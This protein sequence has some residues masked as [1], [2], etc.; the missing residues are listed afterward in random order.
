M[1]AAGGCTAQTATTSVTVNPIQTA[2]VNVGA[3]ATTICL[4]T[5]VTFTATPTNG[6]TTPSY[7]WKLNGSNVGTDSATYT[8]TTLA[9]G[10]T[11]SVVM[12]S[13]ASPCLTGSPAT[14]NSISMI[15]DPIT[16]G[17]TITGGGVGVCQGATPSDLTLT[18]QTGS[19]LRWEKSTDISFSSPITIVNSATVLS[20]STIGGLEAT[21]YFR[22]VV[23]SGICAVAYSDVTAL[24]ITSTTWN[25][26]QWSDGAPDAST[27]VLITG[28]FTAT[29]DLYACNLTVSNNA[30]VMI[31]QGYDVILSGAL[32]VGTGSTFTLEH[33]SNLTQTASAS[34]AVNTGKIIVKEVTPTLQRQDYAMFSS[35]VIGQK[36]QAFSPNTLATRFYTY[37]PSSNVYSLVASPSATDFATGKGYLIRTPNNHPATPTVWTANY[38]GTPFNGNLTIPV[39][40][41]TYNAIGNPYPSAID[42][43]MFFDANGLTEA[44]YFYRKTNGTN[45]TAYATYTKTGGVSSSVR[46][47]GNSNG[48]SSNSLAPNGIIPVGQGFIV[49]AASSSISFTNAMRMNS[50]AGVQLRS[51]VERHRVWLSMTNTTGFFSQTL[52]AYMTGATNGIDA[53][54]DGRFF[55]DSQTAFTSM[56][57]G[58]EYAI[59]GRQLPFVSS[60]VVAMGFKTELA[61]TYSINLDAVDGIFLSSEVIYL[62]DKLTNTYTNMRNG[63]Y[64]F[65]SLPGVFNDRFELRFAVPPTFYQDADGDGYG[66][67]FSTIEADT[68]PVGYVANSSDCDDAL[69]TVN[70]NATEILGNGIDD[71][72]D[73][74]VDESSYPT[75]VLIATSCGSTLTNLSNTLFANNLVTYTAQYGA[76]Q[77]YR[78]EVSDGQTVRVYNAIANSFNLL[79]LPGGAT[80]G[81]TY[82]VRV[83]VKLGGFWRPYGTT[84][85][86][87]TPAVPNSTSI[88][89]PSC[90]SVMADL[91]SSVFCNPVAGASGYRFRV[92]NGDTIVGSY[93]STI[94][95]FSFMN[96]GISNFAFGVTYSIDV[97]LKF[98]NTWRPD[99]EYGSVCTITSPAAPASSRIVSPLCGSTIASYWTSIFA[100]QI[101]GAEGY[102]FEVSTGDQFY[103]YDSAVSRFN[104]RNV[105]GLPLTANTTYSIRVSVLYNAVYYDYGSEC[106]VTTAAVVSRIADTTSAENA[107][108]SSER[109]LGSDPIFVPIPYPNPFVETFRIA[110]P[111]ERG[112]IIHL[113]IYDLGGKLIAKE[114]VFAADMESSQFG[115]RLQSGDYLLVISQGASIKSMHI[116]KR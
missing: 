93:D 17:G 44:L 99:T 115:S 81:T 14:S 102:R 27:S 6:G 65:S 49:K 113:L 45:S 42:A 53:A 8:S 109:Q 112:D 74:T 87:T 18:G 59:Q 4:G 60:D 15:V 41:G 70:V 56:I 116:N 72:C 111:E 9:N 105:V 51:N 46:N 30:S 1:A 85:S 58:Q 62:K 38:E 52:V 94:N 20:G 68:A 11:V 36:L 37:N 31:P 24:T 19:V 54:I 110:M 77:G 86:V 76:V 25:G 95:R 2:S 97:L 69:A 101:T 28:N 98:G 96:I 16:V 79:N 43:D 63:S 32:T 5:S 26:S 66:S 104:L 29:S 100:Q 91:S 47:G 3:S 84:C 88:V 40:N 82:S 50:G 103:Y 107:S 106:A 13:N 21:T 61:G 114:D 33:D 64:T 10:N 71:N 89:Q 75:S 73:G 90:G 7:Q 22:A 39:T 80:Y 23:Q 67:A 35:P 34:A 108:E 78:F 55:N 83:S 92:R 48:N 57:N 12:T